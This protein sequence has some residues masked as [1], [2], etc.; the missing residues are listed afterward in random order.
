MME[1]REDALRTSTVAAEVSILRPGAGSAILS[2]VSSG[3]VIRISRVKEYVVGVTTT[4][5]P[6]IKV[7]LCTCVYMRVQ[8][9]Q[10]ASFRFVDAVGLLS[11]SVPTDYQCMCST[12]VSPT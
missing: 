9:Y 2:T 10:S 1:T 6:Y 4:L 8:W 7:F 12:S 5:G 3:C 11:L